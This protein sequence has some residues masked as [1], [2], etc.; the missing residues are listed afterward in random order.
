MPTD[1]TSYWQGIAC[2][3]SLSLVAQANSIK[4]F[5]LYFYFPVKSSSWSMPRKLWTWYSNPVPPHNYQYNGHIQSYSTPKQTYNDML[6]T[7]VFPLV[8]LA[9][10]LLVTLLHKIVVDFSLS[11]DFS[12]HF[13]IIIINIPC[14]HI[15]I[16]CYV[17]FMK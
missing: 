11:G 2:A 13:I 7:H 6:L 12:F 10:Q 1:A 16:S 17:Y 15:Y 9:E 4:V 14:T 5:C 3:T 8:Y